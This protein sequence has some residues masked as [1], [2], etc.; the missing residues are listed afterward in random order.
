MALCGHGVAILRKGRFVK[1]GVDV[2]V[3]SVDQGYSGN[4]EKGLEWINE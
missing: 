2:F 4:I 1:P 3:G